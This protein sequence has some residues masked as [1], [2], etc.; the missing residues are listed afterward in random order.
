MGVFGHGQDALVEGQP[1]QFSVEESTCVWDRQR[2][3]QVWF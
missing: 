1:G 2:A 3:R